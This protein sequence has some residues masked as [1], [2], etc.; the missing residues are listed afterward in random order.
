MPE[1]DQ[2]W[3]PAAR[4]VLTRDQNVNGHRRADRPH[5]SAPEPAVRRIHLDYTVVRDLQRRV[6]EHLAPKFAKQEITDAER[7]LEEEKATTQVVTEYVD[8]QRLAG[9]PIDAD[10]EQEFIDA[11]LAE[12]AGLGR[13]HVLLSDPTVENVTIKGHDGVRVERTDG[14]IEV[15]EPIADNNQDLIRKL[16]KLAR[17]A[18]ASE[19]AFGDNWPMMGLQLPGGQR[20][21]AVYGITPEPVAV[22]RVP[23]T[24]GVTLDELSTTTCAPPTAAR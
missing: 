17:D 19:K 23:G 16:Q 10:T 18:G 5:V 12:L 8:Q 20:L 11:V 2:S 1:Y 9:Q 15:V 21:A 24:I 13:L 3:P 6:S 22:I 7:K 14:T 4:A